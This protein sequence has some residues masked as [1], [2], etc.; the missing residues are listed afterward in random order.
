MM[1]SGNTISR[2]TVI[3]KRLHADHGQATFK[4][5]LPL[6]REMVKEIEKKVKEIFDN[7]GGPSLIKSSRDVYIKPN[8]VG[9]AAYVYTRPEVIEAAIRYWFAAGAKNVYLIENCTQANCTRF[10][11]EIIGYNTVCKKTGAVPVC[12]D[13]DDEVEYDFPGKKPAE[14]DPTGYALTTFRMPRM[15][16]EKLIR[17]K[18]A[19]LYVN[20][21]KL[22]THSMGVVTLGIKNQWGFPIHCDRSPDHNYNLPHKIVDVLSHVRPDVTLI[23]GVE[24]T[25]FGH[26]PPLALAD[27]CVRP[28]KVLI[29]G[30]NVVAV[31]IVGAR[32]FGKTIQNVP[33]LKIAL[34]RNL[35]G[36]IQSEQDITITGDY[37]TYDDMDILNE[38]SEYGGQYPDD[39]VPE[40]PKD[41]TIIKGKE[42]ACREGCVNNSMSV[43]QGIYLDQHGKGGWTMIMGK[44]FDHDVIDGITGPVLVVGPCAVNE[45]GSRLVDRL[46]RK[47]V[48]FSRECNDLTALVE[49][50][51][52]LMKVSPFKM[53]PPINL[54]K[55]GYL[56]FQMKRNKSS[57]RMT[58]PLANLIKLR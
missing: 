25:I 58:N 53:A 1:S 16:H 6:N 32:I 45:A 48:Y 22:K 44:G 46:G 42:M 15:V 8:A 5:Y 21:P 2:N 36:G 18:D 3:I 33:H 47:K 9:T 23:E 7:L 49:S 11:F 56:L 20:I 28:F 41:V 27:Q 10:V 12:L 52:H 19:N 34:E 54:I 50:M 55:A 31:D 14:S 43:L 57:A 30:L 39:L 24:G 13:E 26:Y 29:G 37:T 51:C 40:F 38:L 17:E 35:G 4:D